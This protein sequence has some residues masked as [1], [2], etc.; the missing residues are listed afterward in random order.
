MCMAVS[1]RRR[2]GRRIWP[3]SLAPGASPISTGHVRN[4]R[5]FGVP[6]VVA[7]NRF[8]TDSEAELDL[9]RR[10]CREDLHVEAIVCE[11]WA[12][13]R[14]LAGI[15]G[16]A[17]QVVGSCEES[18]AMDGLGFSQL[19]ADELPCGRSCARS[20]ARFRGRG[21]DGGSARARPVRRAGGASWGGRFPIC[22]AKTQYSFSTGSRP[23]GALRPHRAGARGQG[24][25]AG[26]SSWSP[27]AATS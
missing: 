18:H 3:Y 4:I 8:V 2:S 13:R 7:I 9:V 17:R 10:H 26:P 12:R 5:K 1:P 14:G 27:S 21:R 16:L 19:Y 15:A 20:R 6:A 25:P 23:Q 24:L 11:H 22:V